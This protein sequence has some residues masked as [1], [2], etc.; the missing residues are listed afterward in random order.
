MNKLWIAQNGSAHVERSA[1]KS[2][3]CI[4]HH[5]AG[6]LI[7]RGPGSCYGWPGMH[8]AVLGFILLLQAGMAWASPGIIFV[9]GRINDAPVR[10]VVDT[11]ADEILIPYAE[12]IRM[13]LP[14]FAGERIE[15][16]TASGQVGTYK[17]TLDT[18]TVGKITLHNV[19][20]RV[21]ESDLGV[22]YVLLGMSF[23]GRVRMCVI[24]GQVQISE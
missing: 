4:Q 24:N 19:A 6:S 7:W 12:A 10:F 18:V 11:G 9:D 13:G 22:Q 5:C 15:S 21:S 1:Q 20:A 8:S 2:R 23:L 14:V 3:W 16:T 17:L